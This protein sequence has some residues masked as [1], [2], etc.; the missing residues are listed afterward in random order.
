MPDID[1]IDEAMK[2]LQRAKL[3]QALQTSSSGSPEIPS[4]SPEVSRAPQQE[5]GAYIRPDA[6][7]AVGAPPQ[8]TPTEEQ[9][10]SF[11]A[12]PAFQQANPYFNVEQM[13][14][15]TPKREDYHPSMLRRIVAGVAGGGLGARDPQ[16]GVEAQQRILNNP[17]NKQLDDFNQKLGIQKNIADLQ[18]AANKS[19]EEEAYKQAETSKDTQEANL[20]SERAKNVLT[21]EGRERI[22]GIRKPTVTGPKP[23]VDQRRG[24]IVRPGANQG[25]TSTEKYAEPIQTETPQQ[26]AAREEGRQNRAFQLQ[27]KLAAFRDKLL[28]KRLDKKEADRQY[29]STAAKAAQTWA[30]GELQMDPE[31]HGSIDD[32]TLTVTEKD[33]DKLSKIQSKVHDLIKQHFGAK[34]VGEKFELQDNKSPTKPSGKYTV[35]SSPVEEEEEEDE[36]EE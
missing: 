33:P 20:A 16:A 5:S 1:Y 13:E 14:S 12:P 15:L 17:Y 32:K 18:V 28:S 4:P 22:A 9:T 31:F 26:K 23:V 34:A 19:Q 29:S 35:T 27:E 6:P 36:E 24:L 30:L 10:P 3:Q 8:I 2:H 11:K 25:E 7:Q 21:Q